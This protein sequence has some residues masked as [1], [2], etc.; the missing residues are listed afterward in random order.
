MSETYTLIYF[1]VGACIAAG[2]LAKRYKRS[3]F[4]WFVLSLLLSPLLGF[5]FVLALGRRS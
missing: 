4:A 2:I 3:G 5:L 1:W